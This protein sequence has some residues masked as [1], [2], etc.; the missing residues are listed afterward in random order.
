VQAR[1]C[2]LALLYH[3]ARSLHISDS[4]LSSKVSITTASL[5]RSL[6]M[7]ALTPTVWL[8]FVAAL[9]SYGHS[10]EKRDSLAATCGY[11]GEQETSCFDEITQHDLSDT[12]EIQFN[13]DE[14]MEAGLFSSWRTDGM[15]P[16]GLDDGNTFC[17]DFCLQDDHLTC[18]GLFSKNGN[19]AL[20]CTNP[21]GKQFE[22]GRCICERIDFVWEIVD[23]V[24]K[25]LEQLWDKL[26]CP[27]INTGLNLL[28]EIGA[29]AL[30]SVPFVGPEASVGLRAVVQAVRYAKDIGGDL[31]AF[32]LN[33]LK[34]G[35]VSLTDELFG[36]A[37]DAAH[38][39]G[40]GAPIPDGFCIGRRNK[41]CRSD[42]G[43]YDT[44]DYKVGYCC[45][46]TI[47]VK[48]LFGTSML[49]FATGY[50]CRQIKPVG[51]RTYTDI[52]RQGPFCY[53]EYTAIYY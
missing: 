38:A 47:N 24:A 8:V 39:A 53:D 31:G 49:I 1:S 36:A 30:A 13:T 3:S 27:V 44:S 7:K 21:E 14:E 33:L 20:E 52:N 26:F 34:C 37:D 48:T 12:P 22:M 23:A 43:D 17:K 25:G 29:D 6:I 42:S 2:Y 45:L 50:K 35:T 9:P 5:L 18:L 4:V 10:S 41:G 15:C 40:I 32:N 11:K 51:H 28:I 19:P 46:N 16:I